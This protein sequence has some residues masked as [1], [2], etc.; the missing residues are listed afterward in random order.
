MEALTPLQ[1]KLAALIVSHAR[2]SGWEPGY[3]LTEESLLPVLATSRSPIRKAMAWLAAKGV[4]EQR[5]NKGF[6]LRALPASGPK[7]GKAEIEPEGDKI[8]AAIA[9]D[10]LA[11][12]LPDIVSEN[13]L[14]RRYGVSRAQ[15]RL[16]LARMAAEG[17]IERRPGRGWEFLPLIDTVDAY[18][19]NYRFRQIVEPSAMRAPEFR[20]DPAKVA[21]LRAQQRHVRDVGYK[22]LSQIELYEIN[23][24]FHETLAGMS[25]NRFVGQA[26]QRL[27]GL[28]RL[29]EYGWPLDRER[30]RRVCDEHLAI[31][32][33]LDGGDLVLAAARLEAHL[34]AALAEKGRDRGKGPRGD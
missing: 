9:M 29:M 26:L 1:S 18:R 16:S 8:Y 14:I 34:G 5:P 20:V 28:R 10:R 27:N 6:F 7:R 33:A 25:N 30:V 12:T 15:L 32:D 4:L 31:L 3:H 2:L 21:A 17:W 24:Q 13:E 19:E 22:S 11:R 23:A